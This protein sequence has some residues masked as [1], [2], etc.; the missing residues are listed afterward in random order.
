[1][2]LSEQPSDDYIAGVQGFLKFAYREKKSD[3]KIQ[4]PC[5]KCVNQKLQQKDTI[6]H[7]ACDGML[8]GNTIWGCHGETTSYISANKDSNSQHP[9]LNNNM[10]Q[11]VHE[12][13]G[14]GDNYG[15]HTNEPDVDFFDL[16]RD[17]DQPLWEGCELSKLTFLVLLFHVKSN[18]KWSNKS[19]NDFLGILQL[20][21]PNGSNI[22]K[23]LQRL[24]KSLQNLV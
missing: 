16:L 5:I 6:Y 15:L 8:R 11:V 1:L 7:L 10:R 2:F 22:R 24:R 21:L 19:L 17:A 13:F 18:N 9:N 4:C 23:H 14:Y 3:A 12:A 20:A